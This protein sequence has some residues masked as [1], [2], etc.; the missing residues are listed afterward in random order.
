[1]RK[2]ILGLTSVLVGLSMFAGV[3]AATEQNCDI[4]NTGPGS[5]NQ[6]EVNATQTCKLELVEGKNPCNFTAN[7]TCKVVNNTLVSIGNTNVQNATSGQGI[8]TQNTNG[9]SANTGNANNNNSTTTA[10]GITNGSACVITVADTPAT[11]GQGSGT[12]AT[13]AAS[14]QVNVPA[15]GVGAGSDS[16]ATRVATFGILGGALASGAAAVVR[17][18][19]ARSQV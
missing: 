10:V 12:T 4:N 5:N 15:G 19:K 16:L 13:P 7:Q 18:R 11:G 6:C 9:G 8:V 17:L 1:M 14:P 2:V 3:A